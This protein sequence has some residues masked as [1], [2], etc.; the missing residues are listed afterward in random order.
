MRG[1][2]EAV[3]AGLYAAC[4]LEDIEAMLAYCHDDIHYSVYQPNGISGLG[5]EI[6]G[7]NVLRRYLRAVFETWEFVE[8]MHGSL[9]IE[10]GTAG[11]TVRETSRFHVLHRATGLP[12][13]GRK[14]HVWHVDGGRIARC[15]EFQDASQI[16]AFLRMVGAR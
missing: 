16:D 7:K 13:E 14:R 8:V 12:L 4:Q 11:A 1:D 10:G 15:E 6:V 9:R 3:V 2:P 5:G